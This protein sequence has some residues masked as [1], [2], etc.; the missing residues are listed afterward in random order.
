MGA[1]DR[2][3]VDAECSE[4]GLLGCGEGELSGRR[5]RQIEHALI[6]LG[7]RTERTY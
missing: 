3:P 2:L 4:D 1:T 5:A 6:H 7:P